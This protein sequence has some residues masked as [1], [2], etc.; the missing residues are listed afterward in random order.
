[1]TKSGKRC[2]KRRNGWFLLIS[3]FVTMFF[4]KP[5]AAVVSLGTDGKLFNPLPTYNNSAAD[6]F[7]DIK[8]KKNLLF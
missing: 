3:S 6:D 2:G 5:S 4:K 1:M 8:G 7:E